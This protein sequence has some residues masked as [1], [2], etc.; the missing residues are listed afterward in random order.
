L[1]GQEAKGPGTIYIAPKEN[2][3]NLLPPGRPHLQSFQNFLKECHQLRT[4]PSV[5]EPFFGIL[6][7]QTNKE[8]VLL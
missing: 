3:S 5:H 2:S 6:H 1:G 7:I 8:L 4:K